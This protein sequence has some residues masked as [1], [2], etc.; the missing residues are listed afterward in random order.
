MSVQLTPSA[1]FKL[2]LEVICPS[3]PRTHTDQESVAQYEIWR[4]LPAALKPVMD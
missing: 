3:T 2:R 1:L 4:I